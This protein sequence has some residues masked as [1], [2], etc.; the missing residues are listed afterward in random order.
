LQLLFKTHRDGLPQKHAGRN[1]GEDGN[2]KCRVYD[3]PGATSSYETRRI[4]EPNFGG[5]MP[6]DAIAFGDFDNDLRADVALAGESGLTVVLRTADG[7]PGTGRLTYPLPKMRAEKVV[8]VDYDNDGWEDLLVYGAG[9]EESRDA[10]RPGLRMFR[11]QGKRGFEDVTRAL[12]LDENAAVADLAVADFDLDG[13]TDIAAVTPAGL[14]LWRNNGGNANRQLKV[15]LLGNRSNSS[16]LGVRLELAG[17][18]WHTVRTVH[19]LP[20]EIGVGKS[21]KLD[22]LKTRW[23]DLATTIVEV[24]VQPTQALALVELTLPTG[25]CPYLYAWDGSRFRFITDI[26]GR[27]PLVCLSPALCG[28]D[29]ERTWPLGRGDFVRE[30]G[31]MCGIIEELREGFI[32]TARTGSGDHLREPRATHEQ[33]DAVVVSAAPLRMRPWLRARPND[34]GA[35]DRFCE[36]RSEV[37]GRAFVAPVRGLGTFLMD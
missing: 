20:I 23:F 36:R 3:A 7:T 19:R 8:P 28:G 27:L 12:G 6:C 30:R 18:Q 35:I 16:G 4:F 14:H 24:P 11:N 22:L 2:P 1:P 17:E 32:G 5:W 26:L 34:D 33:D 25:S 29:P 15:Q 13:D 21:E 10:T 9:G 31:S 37:A